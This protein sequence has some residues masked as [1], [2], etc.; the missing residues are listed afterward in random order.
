[1]FAMGPAFFNRSS[2]YAALAVTGT[3]AAATVG[4]AYSSSLPITGGLEPYSLTGGTG[5]A[6][7]S[8]DTG[9][10]LSIT[11]T[12]GARFLT[13]ACASPTTADTMSFTASVDS[14]DSQ[15]VTSAQ[16]VTVAASP[17]VSLLHFDGTNG[18]T[19]FTDAVGHIW[20]PLGSAS[21]STARSKF[22]SASGLFPG[23]GAISTPYHSDFDLL[24]ASASTVEGFVYQTTGGDR[25]IFTLGGSVTAA[26]NTTG[27]H[28]LLQV[29]SLGQFVA[30]V[31]NGTS[32]P[33]SFNSGSAHIVANAWQHVAMC[34]DSTSIRL[35]AE[36]NLLGST[37]SST[38]V[39]PSGN[40]LPSIGRITSQGTGNDWI[41]NIDEFRVTKGAA[42]YTGSA[43]TVPT[44][45]F[46]YP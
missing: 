40:P 6:S 9:F 38:I 30:T 10:A 18:S 1:M 20:T 31:S 3:F 5:I 14:A 33:I 21:I 27:Y 44:A 29:N 11:G 34:I 8:L 2:A 17:T 35:Y 37:S 24:S 43:Y 22:G 41:G 32:A 12:T 13:L 15:S 23:N 19:T 39:R 16:S 26:N 45:P 42:L 7:G 4:V 28:L 25:R 36:G 46:T